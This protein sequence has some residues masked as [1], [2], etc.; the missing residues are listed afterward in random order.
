MNVSSRPIRISRSASH[1]LLAR[2]GAGAQHE[3]RRRR[4]EL[5]DRAAVGPR[6][7]DRAGDDRRQHLVEVEARADRLADLAERAQ[8]VDRARELL[9]A[10]LELLEQ[11]HVLDRDRAL[12]R[13]RRDELDRPVVER[14]DVA[15][16]T[17]RSPRRRGRSAS[18]GT[19]S[20]VR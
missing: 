18:I 5:E 19:P 14:V 3:L 2:A 17:A 13:E 12:G 4:L 9:A 20:I 7:L 15:R 11:L 6:E 8:L 10:L 16:A 1:E